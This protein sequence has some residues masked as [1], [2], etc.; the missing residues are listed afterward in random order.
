MSFLTDWI[1][2]IIIFVL[3][4]TV[5]D[6]LL[7]SSNM[8]KYAKIVTGLLLITIILTPL[9]KLMS[10]D[11]DEVMNSID[12]NGPSQ[13]KSMEN[14]IEMKKKEIQASQRA[15]ILEQMAVQM[16][17]EA[18]KEMM[19][20][21]GKVIEKVTIQAEDVE[22]LPDSITGVTVIVKDKESEKDST[23]ETVQNVEIDT[24]SETRKKTSDEDTSQLAS[25]L[26]EQWNLTQD[27]IIITV[28][29]GTGEA[30]E[31]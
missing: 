22:N 4:A 7:P 12:L 11:F 18:E 3:L 24:G 14:E 25:L 9:F 1:T 19:D 26:A 23:I 16:K 15:Y 27:K 13:N 5:I 17:Q 2:N 31:L 20:E 21:H 10:T 6:M 28:E 8:Q 29:G 30:N